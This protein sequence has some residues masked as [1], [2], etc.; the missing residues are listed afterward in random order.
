MWI[1][2]GFRREAARIGPQTLDAATVEAHYPRAWV[3]E[4]RWF[5]TE[6]YL[7]QAFLAFNRAFEVLW[8]GNFMHL[9][10]ADRLELAFPRYAGEQPGSFWMRR[11][12]AMA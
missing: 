11:T 6:Q 8:A 4:R 2:F 5:W 1:P 9:F 3:L 7:L 10:H 12:P